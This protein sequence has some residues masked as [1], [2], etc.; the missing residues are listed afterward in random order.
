MKKKGS[1]LTTKFVSNCLLKGL[2]GVTYQAVLEDIS[3]NGALII[4]DKD[5]PHGLHVGE[6]CGFML[7]NK[8]NVIPTKHTGR[9]IC[10]DAN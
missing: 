6:M 5:A 7:R 2:D 8:P 4:M 1:D 9:I 3:P 10:L